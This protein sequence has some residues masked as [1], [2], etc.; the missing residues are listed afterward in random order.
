LNI[1]IGKQLAGK[2]IPKERVLRYSYD[3]K[4][5]KSEHYKVLVSEGLTVNLN[6]FIYNLTVDFVK[7][8]SVEHIGK[9]EINNNRP[10]R[11]K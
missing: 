11:I 2:V 4:G 6:N 9:I 8:L 7:N 1:S 5:K 10:F 3:L